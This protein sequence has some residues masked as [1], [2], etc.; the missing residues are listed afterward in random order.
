MQSSYFSTSV[1]NE[2]QRTKMEILVS[3]LG[4]VNQRQ[5]YNKNA[6]I[7]IK[8]KN[9]KNRPCPKPS[10]ES[11][12]LFCICALLLVKSKRIVLC[13][14]PTNYCGHL[15]IQLRCIFPVDITWSGVEVVKSSIWKN[16][17]YSPSK[18]G[19]QAR[20]T[21]RLRLAGL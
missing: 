11:R 16:L 8:Q 12:H 19:K 15:R 2:G 6:K 18:P 21:P 5:K 4:L 1:T 14:A 20:P 17:L 3:N 7:F 10:A 9:K 13:E